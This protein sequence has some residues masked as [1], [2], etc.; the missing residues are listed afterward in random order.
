MVGE[1]GKKKRFDR[2]FKI[3]A[4]KTVVQSVVSHL[5]KRMRDFVATA[6]KIMIET[7]DLKQNE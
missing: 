1:N 4:V 2:D 6:H 3:Q 5:Q 7:N